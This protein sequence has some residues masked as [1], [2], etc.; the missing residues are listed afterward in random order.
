MMLCP[1]TA[2][3]LKLFVKSVSLKN[4]RN[5]ESLSLDLSPGTN[6][7][8][9][10]NAQGKTNLLE[11]VYL[12]GTTRSHRGAKDREMIRMGEEESHIRMEMD[13][14]DNDYRI[15]VHLK[16]NHAKGIAVNGLPLKKAS[17]LLSITGMVFFSPEDLMIIKNGP[18][19][20]RRFLDSLLCGIDPVY[21]GNLARYRKCLMQRGKL[22]RDLYFGASATDELDVWDAQTVYYGTKIIERRES[23]LCELSEIASGIHYSLTG[24]HEHLEIHYEENVSSGDFADKLHRARETDLKMKTTSAGPHRDDLAILSNGIDLRSY[25]SQGQQRTAALSLKLSEIDIYEKAKGDRPILLLDDVFS[26][27]DSQRQTYLTK[28]IKKTQTLL[29]CT[30]LDELLENRLK[31]DQMFH[32]ERGGIKAV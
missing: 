25:G 6:L 7:F 12:A 13:R 5:Y 17:E 1:S 20:R 24:E 9:G 32:V 21:L 26:E 27:L 23:L 11:A 14:R 8:Y 3:R 30:G 10:M 15:D 18:A 29:T 4:F 16:K 28:S 22:L 2:R 19:E 31:A